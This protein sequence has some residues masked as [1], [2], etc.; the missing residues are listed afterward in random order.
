MYTVI[1]CIVAI[2]Q[3][4]VVWDVWSSLWGIFSHCRGLEVVA[5]LTADTYKP[6]LV[7]TVREAREPVR[8]P[9]E[10]EREAVEGG[11]E[12]GREASVDARV[13]S[14]PSPQ[15][16]QVKMLLPVTNG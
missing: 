13:R 2:V 5:N 7:L 11:Q 1:D 4:T 10:A 9:K 14:L 6:V 3:C 15:V 12:G 16:I 8:E